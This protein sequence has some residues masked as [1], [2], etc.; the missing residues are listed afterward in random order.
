MAARLPVASTKRATASTLGPIEPGSE[1]LAAQLIGLDLLELALLVGARVLVHPVDIRGQDQEV[2]VDLPRQQLAGE[3]LVDHGLH[4]DETA[5]GV[6]EG[7]RG[8]TAAAGADHDHALIQEPADRPDL[9]DALGLGGGD[10]GAS[11]RS[12]VLL[13]DPCP[14]LLPARRLLVLRVHRSDVLVGSLNA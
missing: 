13:E 6:G 5:H 9:E 2:R 11:P 4:P 12:A 8:H 7:H 3:V 14:R 10:Y 1:L